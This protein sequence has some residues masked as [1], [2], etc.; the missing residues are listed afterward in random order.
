MPI[1]KKIINKSNFSSVS[2]L[3]IA[4]FAPHFA[5]AQNNSAA[6]EKTSAPSGTEQSASIAS[7]VQASLNLPFTDGIG[8]LP[9]PPK[10]TETT[11]QATPEPDACTNGCE[12]P[13]GKLLGSVDG[14][15]S[16]S[17]CKS[18]CVKPEYSFLDFST[19]Q[20]SVHKKDPQK[21][22]LRYIG[23][24]YQCVEYARK[25]WMKNLG[26]TFGS[27]DSAHE[28]IYLTEG[29]KIRS[30]DKFPLARSINGTASRAPK[31]GDL[32]I[33]YPDATR[34]DWK[35]GH[36][37]VVVAVNLGKGFVDLA[38]E[39]Y[40]NKPWRKPRAYSR[41]ISIYQTGGQY[42]LIDLAPGARADAKAGRISGWIYPK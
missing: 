16:F 11:P 39:N 22:D 21:E 35:H 24:T 17:N 27:I 13:F 38:E 36:V 28:I 6:A 19:G 29:E 31:R 23:V 18:T 20:V 26:I 7:A 40:D 25:W 14:T 32:V 2:I 4:L 42:T 12:T 5:S 34:E 9:K 37:A 10:P 15:D 33:Y 8:L 41:R 1:F 30:K 3:V